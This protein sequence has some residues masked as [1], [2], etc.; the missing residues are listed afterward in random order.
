M[1]QLFSGSWKPC[2]R[3]RSDISRFY[4]H[5]HAPP[6][7]QRT[8]IDSRSRQ[9]SENC[10]GTH[11]NRES[12]A[13]SLARS[14]AG[15]APLLN[16]LTC[17]DSALRYSISCWGISVWIHSMSRESCGANRP[18]MVGPSAVV[19]SEEGGQTP[20]WGL[21]ESIQSLPPENQRM[22]LYGNRLQV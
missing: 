18:G 12:S 15:V 3:V 10:D 20:S 13:H 6:S 19:T 1:S 14:L 22:P 4:I 16:L 9:A 2:Y 17:H 5:S 8:L 21:S 7:P 11:K